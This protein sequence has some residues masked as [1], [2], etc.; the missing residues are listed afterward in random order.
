MTKG[1]FISIEGIEGAGKS[2]VMQFIRDSLQNAN[3][4]VVWTREPGGTVLAEDIRKLVLHS[5]TPEFVEPET[6]LLM[7]FAGRAQH[8]KNIILPAL[9]AGKWVVSDRFIDASY[10]YQGGGRNID[11]N[12]IRFLDEKIVGSAYPDLT[13]LLDI[14]PDQGFARTEMRG[15][16]KDRIE[17]ENINFF[18]RV[19][20]AYLS[21]A[22]Q[23]S[24]RIKIIDASKS[25]AEVEDQVGQALQHFIKS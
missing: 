11:E 25:I 16:K 12:F 24:K 14:S 9:T 19:R 13:L 18:A 1:K 4:D 15:N 3:I 17:E 2:T 6:E 21:R 20:D 23:D 7:M 8:L 22:K 5:S 10:A